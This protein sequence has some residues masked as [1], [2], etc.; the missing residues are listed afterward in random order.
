MSLVL[1]VAGDTLGAVMIGGIIG[2][3]LFG[4]TCSQGY[5]YYS[6]GRKDGPLMRYYVLA[7]W[8]IDSIQVVMM[9]HFLYFSF[10]TNYGVPEVFNTPIWSLMT[11]VVITSIVSFMVRAVYIQGIWRLS[12]ENF[13]ITGV[14]VL[15]SLFD[16]VCGIV[17][18][19]KG[20][21]V[22]AGHLDNLKT[23]L[24]LNFASAVLADAS[25]ALTLMFL[26]RGRRSG[27]ARLNSFGNRVMLFTVN[28]GLLTAADAAVALIT[29]AS[30]PH[31]FVFFAPY[32]VISHFYTNALFASL[33]AR[34]FGKPSDQVMSFN[35]SSGASPPRF[36]TNSVSQGSQDH[37]QFGI[38]IQTTVQTRIDTA[39]DQDLKA[40]FT[41]AKA[42]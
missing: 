31:K 32:M 41:L 26:L 20:Y 4:L 37:P 30:M 42:L 1:D 29:Y 16:F 19:V 22:A 13:A 5:M 39:S 10:V 25:V 27:N 36:P 15:L 12:E 9:G 33:N 17:L 7:I 11:L 38:P 40:S 3:T 14:L 8:L 18:S 28:T 2:A 35:F 24:Y 23:S 6:R 34:T 21:N